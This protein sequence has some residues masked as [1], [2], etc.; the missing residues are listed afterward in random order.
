[1]VLIAGCLIPRQW[2]KTQQEAC[3]VTIY[4]GGNDVHTNLIV[5]VQTDD[6][7]WR[8]HLTLTAIGRSGS[9]YRYLSFGWG[10]RQFYLQTPT[11]SDLRLP[12]ALRALLLP[13]ETVLHIQGHDA[14]PSS[15]EVYRVKPIGLSQ[16]GYLQLTNFLLDSFARHPAGNIIRIR[17]SH[18]YSGSFFAAKGRYSLVRTCNDWTAEGLRVAKVNTPL[19][20]GLAAPVMHHAATTCS[21][22][23]MGVNE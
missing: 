4:V 17:E 8:Q 1:M 6:F 12:V 5:P 15:S 19:W 14:V 11:W 16:S 2:H 20:A 13:T 21:T 10:D 3:A 18:R 9:D 23:S 7:D 22:P